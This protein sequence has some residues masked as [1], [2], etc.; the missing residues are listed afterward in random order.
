MIEHSVKPAAMEGQDTAGILSIQML[1][2]PGSLIS[3]FIQ[4]GRS[5]QTDHLVNRVVVAR[6]YKL[7]DL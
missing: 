6:T 5:N 4:T 3:K 7:S 1:K 2:Q